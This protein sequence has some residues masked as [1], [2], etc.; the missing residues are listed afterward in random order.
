MMFALHQ[1][2]RGTGQPTCI[3]V[4]QY[5]AVGLSTGTVLVFGKSCV[6]VV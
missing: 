3:A 2:S 1:L 4:G 5:I 6:N